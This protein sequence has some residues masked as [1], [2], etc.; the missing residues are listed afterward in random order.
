LRPLTLFLFGAAALVFLAAGGN[1][2]ALLVMR[3]STQARD[4]ALRVALGA[5]QF[6]IAR[7]AIS[8]SVLL[9]VAG[10]M[11]GLIVAQLCLSL[12]KSVARAEIPRLEN[13]T[14]DATVFI[15]CMAAAMTWVSTLGTTPLWR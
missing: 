11:F 5:G 2:A 9:G 10:A 14:I 8:E 3:A 12:G 7:Q 1:V 13:A 6:G 15:F 4:V